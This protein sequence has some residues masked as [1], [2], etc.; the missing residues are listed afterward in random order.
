ML[1][2]RTTYK[3]GNRFYFILPTLVKKWWVYRVCYITEGL[4]FHFPNKIH[5][6]KRGDKHTFTNNCPS[7][8]I[9]RSMAKS[10]AKD[11]RQWVKGYNAYHNGLKEV[12]I[13]KV[14]PAFFDGWSLAIDS[15]PVDI[16]PIAEELF[17]RMRA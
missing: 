4:E 17:K 14:H 15:K 2:F 1:K 9:S 6:Y 8:A 7:E 12:V 5:F 11:N 10:L 16:K 3:G 13:D